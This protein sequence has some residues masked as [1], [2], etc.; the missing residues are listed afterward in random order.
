M[1]INIVL[2]VSSMTKLSIKVSVVEL[3]LTLEV[4]SSN[5]LISVIS[6]SDKLFCS[7]SDII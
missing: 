2:L 7:V 6:I 3:L 1:M 5:S 4:F